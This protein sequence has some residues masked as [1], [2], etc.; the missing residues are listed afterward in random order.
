MYGDALLEELIQRHGRAD[1]D[2][3]ATAA[4]FTARAVARA[5]ADHVEPGLQPGEVMVAGGGALNPDLMRR[6][7]TALAPRVVTR[8]DALGVP[9]EAREAMSF[10]I[11]AHRTALGLPSTWPGITGVRHPVVLGK[12]SLPMA[13]GAA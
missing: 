6:L 5:L 8:S 4:E 10:A 1:A 13:S 12:V 7:A 9:I 11:L 2:L 3:L